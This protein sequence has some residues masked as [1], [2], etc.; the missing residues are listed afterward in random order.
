MDVDPLCLKWSP[1]VYQTIIHE[2]ES[3]PPSAALYHSYSSNGGGGG[4]GSGR[5]YKQSTS[6]CHD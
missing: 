6:S 5:S 1:Y 3:S 2:S 4:G